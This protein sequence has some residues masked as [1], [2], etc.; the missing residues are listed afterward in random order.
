MNLKTQKRLAAQLLNVGRT[1]VYFD[2]EKLEEIKEAITKSDLRS[3]I[4]RGIIKKKPQTGISKFRAR[5]RS[6][7]RKKGRQQG[8]GTR[9][10]KRTSR[11]SRKREWINKIRS[12]RYLLF[13]LKS[14]D[15][16]SKETFKTIYKKSKGGFFR[17]KSHIMLYLNENK[18]LI[19]KDGNK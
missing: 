1:R 17:S 13:N 3:L 7:Q 11:L 16:I 6:L 2:P 18:L 8:I 10:G 12:Q 9:K 5:K 14:K 15:R 4:K 19:N